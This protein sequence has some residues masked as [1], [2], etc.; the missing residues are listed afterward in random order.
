MMGFKKLLKKEALA[1]SAK[2]AFVFTIIQ[3]VVQ[4]VRGIIFARVLGPSEYGVYTLA[5]FFIPLVAT[6]AKLGVPSCFTRYIPQYE[7]QGMMKDFIKRT[8]AMAMTGSIVVMI[9]CIIFSRQVAY[10][11]YESSDY[12]NIV[13]L[14]AVSIIA[15][16]LFAC[17]T[18]TFN[19][20][21]VFKLSYLLGFVQFLIFSAI[22]ITLVLVYRDAVS[23]VF[24]N[25]LALI[26]VIFLFGY[27][28]LKYIVGDSAQKQKI[29]ER[30]FKTKIFKYSIWFV[31]TPIVFNLFKYTDRWMIGRF[32]GMEEVGIYSVGSNI[33]ALVF[34]VGVVAGSVLMPNLSSMWEEGKQRE[35]LAKMDLVMRAN[36]V[37]LLIGALCLMLVKT[38]L[39]DL[40]YGAEYVNCTPVIGMLLVFWLLNSTYGI[41]ASYAGLIEKTYILLIGSFAGLIFNV[42]LNYIFIPRY[43]I[44]GAAAATTISF[45]ITI[46]TILIWYNIQGWRMGLNTLI[47]CLLPCIFLFDEIVM[48]AVCLAVVVTVLGTEFL[49]T[50]DEK[51]RLYQQFKNSIRPGRSESR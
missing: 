27:F 44:A 38:R 13:I 49:I 39:I 25:L 46:L 26:A 37:L 30:G 15:Y 32:L 42:S 3:R 18:Y 41:L 22:G 6:V 1:E 10:L 36:T 23:A 33:T 35:A 45:G 48:A 11:I 50:K 20:L 29:E 8:Y 19:G 16:T 47:T 2:I 31:I 17:M 34:M 43:G 4:T 21:R 7:K 9:L 24:A 40:L 51:K 14:C 12:K 5:F 28:V